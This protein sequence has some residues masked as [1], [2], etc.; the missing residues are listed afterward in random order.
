[1]PSAMPISLYIGYVP[2]AKHA[3]AVDGGY[4]CENKKTHKQAAWCSPNGGLITSKAACQTAAAAAGINFASTAG[5]E[6]HV[7]CII[8]GGKAYFV[9]HTKASA[10]ATKAGDGGYLCNNVL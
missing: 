1:M 8:N 2:G 6:W 10:K 9:A 4:L 5:P 7:G 3:K